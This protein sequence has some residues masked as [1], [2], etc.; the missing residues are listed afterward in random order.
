MQSTLV[1]RSVLPA[2]WQLAWPL[3]ITYL[4]SSAIGLVDS[5]LASFLGSVA[6]SA[7]GIADQV[8][9]MTVMAGT[10]LSVGVVALVSRSV[11]AADRRQAIAYSRDS[12]LLAIVVGAAATLSGVLFAD[13][14]FERLAVGPE[15]AAL[16]ARYLRICSFANLPFVV[17]MCL[18]AIFRSFNRPQVSLYL[19]VVT[20]SVSIGL[21]LLLFYGLLP[22][23][24]RS[25]DAFSLSWL[26][27]SYVG[28]SAGLVWLGC[29][30][31]PDV[32]LCRDLKAAGGRVLELIAVALPAVVTEVVWVG[33][34]LCIYGLL[35]Q[36]PN[37]VDYQAAWTV[38][39]K[40]EETVALP[41]VMALSMAVATIVGQNLGAGRAAYAYSLACRAAVWGGVAML[42]VGIAIG[43]F[44]EPCA[45]AFAHGSQTSVYTVDLLRA[46]PVTVPAMA[47]CLILFGAMEGAGRTVYP[48]MVNTATLTLFRL[49]AIAVVGVWLGA[50]SFGLS[51]A[52]V[53]SRVL[54]LAGAVVGFRNL[55][56]GAPGAI[57][58]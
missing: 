47:F 38:A 45:Q 2:I 26:A 48:M 7:L 54:C 1:G 15:V 10:G 39:I 43:V 42:V 51:L 19:W 5:Y 36:L 41:P 17:A 11:G 53:I 40:I 55:R 13:L 33:S 9:F 58:P 20:A 46:A 6:Q 34:N 3:F 23:A 29:L 32:W 28:A 35:S 31:G 57:T 8:I 44:A 16:G 18:S 25:L 22:G 56:A 27:G 12:I 52:L 50:G 30:L 14:V 21:S 37:A 24:A 49:P 4:F